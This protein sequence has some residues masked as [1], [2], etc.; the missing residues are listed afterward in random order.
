MRKTKRGGSAKILVSLSALAAIGMILGKFLAIN[1]TDVMRFSLENITI[2]FSGIVFGP[3]LGAAVGAVQDIVGCIAVGYAINPIITLGCAVNGFI[4]GAVFRVMKKAPSSLSICASVFSAHLLG[5]VIIKSIGLSWFYG[6][7]FFTTL[8][9]RTLNYV[10]VGVAEVLTLISLLNS[11]QLLSQI[12]KIVPF[13]INSAF[14]SASNA[15]EYMSVIS[16]VFS[17]PGLE[18]VEALLASVGSPEKEVKLVHV[19]GTNGKGSTCAFLTSI[20]SASGLKVGSFNS[21]YLYEMRESIRISNEPIS[22]EK[23]SELFARLTQEAQKMQDKPTAFEL[24]TAAAYLAFREEGVDIAVVECGMGGTKDATNVIHAPLLSII[25]GIAKDHVSF[26]G[27]TLAKIAAEKAG[28]IKSG[29]PI[30]VGQMP[31][32]ALD[33]I[34]ARA[35]ALSANIHTPIDHTVTH[36]SLDGTRMD[37]SDIKDIY[38]PLLGTHQ[39]RNAALAITAAQ[40]LK[41]HF[42]TITDES[43]KEGIGSTKWCGRFEILAHSPTFIFDGAHNLDGIK[44]ATESIKTYFSTKIVCLTGVLADKEYEAMAD[45]LADVTEFAVTVTP[46]NPRALS[47]D[48]YAAVLSSRGI[49]TICADSIEDGVAKALSIARKHDIPVVTLGSLYLCREV[50]DALARLI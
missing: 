21:P 26:L 14:K 50:K 12:N 5:S 11:K 3:L 47:N 35:N 9:W 42:P 6:L 23:L 38:L 24:L 44:S 40:I 2:L 49:V 8:L 20:L 36:A 1:I 13:K 46:D 10:I 32:E 15:S 45:V 43:I 41:T 29:C 34:R 22:E 37:T 25:T 4:A 31:T 17:K 27:D 19:A 7:P 28:I 39:P 48:D 30:L 18:R 16:D 33:V